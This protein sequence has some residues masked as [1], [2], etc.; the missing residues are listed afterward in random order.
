[1]CAEESIDIV[2]TAFQFTATTLPEIHTTLVGVTTADQLKANLDWINTS[3][4]VVALRKI[5]EVL[6]PVANKLWV[7][8]GSEENIALAVSGFWANSARDEDNANVIVGTSANLGRRNEESEKGPGWP[9]R[10]G[11]GI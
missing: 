3:V 5:S 2:K 11:R 9:T 10:P 4:D 6:A 7:E 1:M 8:R